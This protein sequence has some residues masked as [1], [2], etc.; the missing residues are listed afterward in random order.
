MTHRGRGGEAWRWRAAIE[1]RREKKIAPTLIFGSA[2][3]RKSRGLLGSYRMLDWV[4]REGRA[5][6]WGAN[7]GQRHRGE[8]DP[9]PWAGPHP[10][11]ACFPGER[12]KFEDAGFTVARIGARAIEAN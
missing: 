3:G 7:D 6:R 9:A 12:G 11:A 8:A 5:T 2:I 10:R 4:E 1:A